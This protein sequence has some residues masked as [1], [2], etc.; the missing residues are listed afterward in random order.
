MDDFRQN[1]ARFQKVKDF[2]QVTIDEHKK[3]FDADNIRDFIDS[4]LL[5]IEVRIVRIISS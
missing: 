3:T 5:E 4:Y 2:L 1:A